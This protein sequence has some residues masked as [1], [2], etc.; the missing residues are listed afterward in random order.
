MPYLCILLTDEWKASNGLASDEFLRRFWKPHISTEKR[1]RKNRIRLEMRNGNW[2]KQ[3]QYTKWTNERRQ[4]TH[5][6]HQQPGHTYIHACIH[7]HTARIGKT[8]LYFNGV[9]DCIHFSSLPY[10]LFSLSYIVSFFLHF[11]FSFSYHTFMDGRMDVLEWT[12]GWLVA[13]KRHGG[14]CLDWCWCWVFFFFFFF[15]P[16]LL[17]AYELGGHFLFFFFTFLFLS[18]VVSHYKLSL[19]AG[20]RLSLYYY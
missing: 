6:T 15:L 16:F 7:A 20:H 17:A 8:S 12:E 5:G 3:K 18:D 19:L 14:T 9:E 2:K 13:Y 10:F 4:V 11:A 1:K